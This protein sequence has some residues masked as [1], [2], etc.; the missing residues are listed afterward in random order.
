M[1]FVKDECCICYEK[2][3]VQIL[4]GGTYNCVRMS[5]CGSCYCVTNC[6]TKYEQIKAEIGKDYDCP[7]CRTPPAKTP[8]EDF[9]RCMSHAKIG[10]GWALERVGQYYYQGIGVSQS[11]TKAFE[12]YSLAAEKG[13]V[14]AQHWVGI[15]Y[16]KG[17]GVKQSYEKSFHF[18]SQAAEQGL[19]NALYNLALCY[20]I[21]SGIEKSMENAVKRSTLATDNGIKQAQNNLA[22][23]YK[24][25]D[26]V[27]QNYEKAV[28]HYTLAAE[29][30]DKISQFN[31]ALC[32]CKVME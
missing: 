13:E 14:S 26:G 21:G 9:D 16:E 31:L 1:D 19:P 2:N 8:K 20:L 29:Q 25:G 5:C 23:Y 15:M 17:K 3:L 11:D 27:E 10:R 6:R 24:Y 32:Y 7:I 12:F 4:K 18:Y 30:D 22:I 28:H